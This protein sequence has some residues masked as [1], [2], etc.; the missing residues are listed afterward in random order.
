MILI[1]FMDTLIM[2]PYNNVFSCQ[3]MYF[4]ISIMQLKDYRNSYLAPGEEVVS[5]R[6]ERLKYKMTQLLE[7]NYKDHI[8][9]LNGKL[10]PNLD[11][12]MVV[13]MIRVWYFPLLT[14][15]NHGNS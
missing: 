8:L 7:S 6:S 9:D 2:K 1:Q 14:Y 10:P 13:K 11:I 4:K 15:K 12:N 5:T 3:R